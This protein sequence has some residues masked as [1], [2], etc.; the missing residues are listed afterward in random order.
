MGAIY[1]VRPREPG[2]QTEDSSY[3]HFHCLQTF[4]LLAWE[5]SPGL[6]RFEEFFA[7]DLSWFSN[8]EGQKCLF[9]EIF[10]AAGTRLEIGSVFEV[11]DSKADIGPEGHKLHL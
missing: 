11:I 1:S 9:E 8:Q 10:K 5:Q 7:M 6:D 4:R 3:P 2:E